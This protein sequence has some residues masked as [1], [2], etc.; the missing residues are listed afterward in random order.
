MAADNPAD[1]DVRA[2]AAQFLLQAG[3]AQSAF[4]EFQRVLRMEPDDQEALVGSGDSALALGKFAEA[5]RY[6][7][8]AIERGTTDPQVKQDRELCAEAADLDPYVASMNDRERRERILRLFVQANDRAKACL[9]S[10][11][12]GSK[13]PVPND[14]K[15]LAASRAALPLRVTPTDFKTH[16]EWEQAA[17][18]WAFELEKTA[19]AR[20]GPGTAKDM[21]IIRIAGE[22][23][24]L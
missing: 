10:V 20:C 12:P 24:E 17:L 9:P 11:L 23:K 15:D 6:F 4:A 7:S 5:E 8:R 22:H 16:P 3:D 1:P 21:A 13:G 14:L 19:T 2:L 18:S